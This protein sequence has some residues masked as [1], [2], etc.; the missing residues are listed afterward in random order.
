MDDNAK[1]FWA[2]TT[3]PVG[4]AALAIVGSAPAHTDNGCPGNLVIRNARPG[5]IVCVTPQQ[6][7][8]VA[9]ENAN[10]D[11]NR[12]PDGG[13]YGP[14]TCQPGFVWREAFDG[15]TAC[16]TVDRRTES[17]NQTATAPKQSPYT[18]AP[19]QPNLAPPNATPPLPPPGYTGPTP[20]PGY[21]GPTLTPTYTPPTPTPGVTTP[22]PTTTT[23]TTT[24]TTSAPPPQHTCNAQ[25]DVCVK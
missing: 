19:A 12:Q 9:Q 22:T 16:V 17:K 5:D 21:T 20:T 15:D 24:T 4:F 14:M 25:V 11:N 3:C 8:Q 1:R 23:T 7:A 2:M 18:P 6:A 10:P 13:A